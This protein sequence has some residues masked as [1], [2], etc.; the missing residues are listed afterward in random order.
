[1]AF[2]H[3]DPS[4]RDRALDVGQP[5]LEVPDTSVYFPFRSKRYQLSPNVADVLN[6][7]QY[8][9]IIELPSCKESKGKMQI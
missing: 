5:C 6:P 9:C 4:R 3:S 8:I 2:S 7:A 1:M